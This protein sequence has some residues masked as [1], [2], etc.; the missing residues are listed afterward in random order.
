MHITGA[1]LTKVRAA[2]A[3]TV[4]AGTSGLRLNSGRAQ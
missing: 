1:A 2:I 3:K 4:K